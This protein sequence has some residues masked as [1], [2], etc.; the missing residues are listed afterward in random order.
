MQAIV[1]AASGDW[2]FLTLFWCFR[3]ILIFIERHAP[4]PGNSTMKLRMDKTLGF[5]VEVAYDHIRPVHDN[6]TKRQLMAQILRKYE[7][8]GH[9]MRCLDKQG[10]IAWKAS[11]RFLTML[12]DA[13]RDAQDELKN[14]L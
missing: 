14:D 1:A 9:A 13:E 5:W 6:V 2:A 12:A 10:K 7:E 4:N 11:P 8:R 3:E